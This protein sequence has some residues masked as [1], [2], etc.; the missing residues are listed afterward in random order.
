MKYCYECGTKLTEKFLENE[1]MIPYC[2]TCQEFRLP[3]FSTA[4]SMEIFN[5]EKDKVLLI[6]QYGKMRNILVAGYVN[7]G[8]SA[9]H[10]MVREV[11]EEVGL[12]VVEYKFNRSE[13]FE[14]SNTLMIN[15]A[16]VV[17]SEDLSRRT[18][19]VDKAE[20]FPLEEAKKEIYHNSLAEKFLL[21]ALDR[22]LYP[23]SK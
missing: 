21:G 9:E 14:K 6:Q 22:H 8:E 16:C 3:I 4:V 5:P 18:K 19:E 10:A 2:E 1:G 7:K 12:H 11:M 23:D 20:W 15:F 17:D 13:Y